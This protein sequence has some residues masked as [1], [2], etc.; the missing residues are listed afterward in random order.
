MKYP[1]S[2]GATP[3]LITYTANPVFIF[4]F[5]FIGTGYPIVPVSQQAFSPQK[6][7][8]PIDTSSQRLKASSGF[9]SCVHN[10]LSFICRL[11]GFHTL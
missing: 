3:A 10:Q 11:E 4:V 2:Y 1:P 9:Y 7:N 5:S 6:F 8:I